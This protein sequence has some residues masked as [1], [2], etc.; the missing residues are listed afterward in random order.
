MRPKA[1]NSRRMMFK[2]RVWKVDT[3]KPRD[4]PLPSV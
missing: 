2:P 4:S 3:I 1:L